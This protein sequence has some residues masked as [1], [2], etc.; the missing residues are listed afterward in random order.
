M[1]WVGAFWTSAFLRGT[2][3]V[4]STGFLRR[5]AGGDGRGCRI[6]R[7]IEEEFFPLTIWSERLTSWTE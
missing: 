5:M 7:E 6:S 3:V 1:L 2:A 4:I